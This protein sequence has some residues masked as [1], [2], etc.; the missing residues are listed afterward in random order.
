MIRVG[1]DVGGTHT[2]L[3]LVDGATG[4]MVV[5]KVPTTTADPS[6]GVIAAL[7][8]LLA[9]AGAAAADVG[10]F[11][12]GTTVATNIVLEHNGARTGLI[13]TEGFRDILHIAR[14]KRP[15]TF[16]LQLDLPWQTH[17]LVRRR[18]R[19]T[20]PERIVPP[21]EVVL[22]LDEAALRAAV[23]AL[24]AEGVEAIAICFLHAYLNPVHEARAK[25]IA[26]EIAPDL[27]ICASHEVI[28]L[29]REYERFSTTALNAFVGPKSARY[30]QRLD[31]DLRVAGVS[32]GLHLMQSSGGATTLEGAVQRPVNLLMSGPAGGLIG[33]I[34]IG[35]TAGFDSVITLDVGGT[36]ADIGIAPGGNIRFR[37]ILDTRLGDYHAMVPMAELDAIGAGGGSIA[38]IDAGGQFQVGPRSAGAEPGPC[39]Y[40]RG[41]V[42]PTATDCLVALGR[43]DPDSFLG[44]RLPLRADLARAAIARA[45]AGPLG[46]SVESAA[47]GAIHILTHSM[48]QAIEVASVRSGLDPRD[49]ALVAF[50]GGGPLFA[51]DIARELAVPRVIIPTAPGLTSALGLLASDVS[52]EQSRTVMQTEGAADLGQIAAVFAAL[53]DEIR[54]QLARD[55]FADPDMRLLRHADCRYVGQGYE[56]R[57]PAPA[58]AVD[59]GFVAALHRAFDTEHARTYGKAFPEKRIQIVNLRVTGIGAIAPLVPADLASGG[60]RPEPAALKGVHPAVF[61]VDGVTATLDT[62]RFRREALRAGNVIDGPSIIDQMDTTT[63]LPPGT[64]ATVDRHGTLI[65]DILP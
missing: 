65:V 62:P 53:E 19:M 22:P 35:R 38:R 23:H 27:Y 3:V 54:A 63:V 57:T 50:G 10:Q 58:S 49:F 30:L 61:E 6:Q 52:Y 59:T 60:P 28:P 34:W 51:C 44:G 33:G 43:I 11:M 36:S 48:V 9:M 13:T 18:H 8:E 21:G 1:A 29:Y 46:Q 41:G 20:V 32:G 26:A 39:C 5:H 25:A 64:R 16:S 42:E 45:L 55:G 24:V 17:P 15:Q 47:L 4:R 31:T 7:A 12:H 2:D 56:L 14:H 37:H 40:G